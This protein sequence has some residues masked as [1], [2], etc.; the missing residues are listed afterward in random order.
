M[1][2]HFKISTLSVGLL[3]ATLATMSAAETN[4]VIR[5][6]FYSAT[7]RASHASDAIAMKGIVV[8]VGAQKNAHICY[9]ADMLRV[10]MAWTGDFLEFGDTLNK[11]AWPPPPQVKGTAMFEVRNG[12]GWAKG[13]SLADVRSNLQGPLPKSWAH[14]EG[15][16]QHGDQV[17]LSYKVG[18][19]GVLESPAFENGIFIRTIQFTKSAADQILVLADGLA[20]SGLIKHLMEPKS[21]TTIS[22][23]DGRSLTVGGSGLPQ[24]A[25]VEFT[26]DGKLVLFLPKISANKPFQVFLSNDPTA[27]PFA[28]PHNSPGD[29]CDLTKGGPAHWKETV[30]TQGVRSSANEAYVVDT[31]TEPLENPWNAKT[32]FGGFD[33]FPD[34]RAA[35]CTFHGDV[36]IVSGIDDSLEKITWKRF[37]TGLFQPLG[38][39]VVDGK[40]YVLGRDQITRLHDLNN[41]GEADFYENFNNDTVVTANYHEFCLD[42]HTDRAGNFYF[43]KGAPWE[44]EVTSPHQGCLLKVSKDGSKLEVVATGFRAPNGMT[45]GPRDEITVSDNQGHWMPSSKLNWIEQGGFYG[46][47]PSAQRSLTLQRGGTNFMANPSDPK[48]RVE[49]KF[50]GWEAASPIPTGYGQPMAWLPQNMDNSSGGQVWAPGKKWGPLSDHL[51]FMSYGKCTLFEVMPEVVDGTRQA[52]MVQL[53]LKFNSGLMR[54]RVNPRD[55][56]V[57]LSGLRGWQT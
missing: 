22:M 51:L 40:V 1:E 28:S 3:L 4:E 50:K 20:K 13:G 34:G 39:K 36:F 5:G 42:L 55:G 49:F 6:P 47:T 45:I 52:S 2:L 18:D 19:V 24:G 56:Q 29:L 14:Y 46:M 12:P 38:V 8:T 26:D 30:V 57:Y 9:D 10:S 23:Q 33:F 31:I 16:Y 37:A 11:I 21:P 41:D 15:L 32:F 48:A 27:I 35:I 53:P 44:P 25:R 54:G 17:I 7:I 43:A